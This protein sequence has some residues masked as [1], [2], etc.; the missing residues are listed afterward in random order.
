MPQP[1][2]HRDA[3]GLRRLPRRLIRA[4]AVGVSLTMLCGAA[5]ILHRALAKLSWQEVLNALE[6]ISNAHIALSLAATAVSFVMLAGFDVV[7][8]RL[9]APHQ[10]TWRTAAFAGAVSQSVSNTLGFHAITGAAIRFRIYRARGV[11]AGDI[12][13]IVSLAG[14]GVVMGFVVVIAGALCWQP[15]ITHS[16]GRL[17]GVLLAAALAG[18]L[19]WLSRRQRSVRLWR[20]RLEF[21]NARIAALQMLIGAVEMCAAIGALYVL[22]PAS[23]APPFVDFLPLYVGAALAGLISH[24]PGGLGVFESIMLA[25]FPAEARADLLAAMLCYRVTY[26]L[27]PFALGA[28]AL[29]VLELRERRRAAAA[30]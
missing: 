3:I 17:P 22:L 1:P 4:L 9:T 15:Q 7:A 13:R 8:A 24:S 14:L 6:Q 25:A 10:V 19:V 23:I 29:G 16:W 11:G 21:P 30:A 12:V 18:L 5:W 27:L 20:W 26:N 2:P 28:V